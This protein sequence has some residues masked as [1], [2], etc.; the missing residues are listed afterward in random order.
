MERFTNWNAKGGVTML[1]ARLSISGATMLVA[2]LFAG[3][4]LANA[5]GFDASLDQCQAVT[6]PA[7]LAG[8]AAS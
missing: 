6:Q 5:Q 3:Y 8:C 4:G 1:N 2:A 7:A